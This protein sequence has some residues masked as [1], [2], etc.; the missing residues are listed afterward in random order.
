MTF[1]KIYRLLDQLNGFGRRGG[2]G[3]VQKIA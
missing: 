1:E 3:R 2:I